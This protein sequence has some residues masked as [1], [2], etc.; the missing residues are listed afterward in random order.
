MMM[1]N[2]AYV[3]YVVPK[4]YVHLIQSA[5]E[6]G[7]I[8]SEVLQL[9]NNSTVNETRQLVLENLAMSQE[10]LLIINATKAL[11]DL[12]VHGADYRMAM[13]QYLIYWLYN[14]QKLA[15]LVQ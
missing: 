7:E 3:D 5:M 1:K 15:E 2:Q 10:S 13:R 4:A 8:P 9:M 12:E 6:L 11:G 14:S